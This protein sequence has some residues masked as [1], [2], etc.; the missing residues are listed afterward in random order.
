MSPLQ[1]L[2]SEIEAYIGQRQMSDT[3]FGKAVFN[4]GKFVTQLRQGR[5]ITTRTMMKARQY[6]LDHPADEPQRTGSLG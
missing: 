4:D 3:A 2:L 1:D 5:D 6:M